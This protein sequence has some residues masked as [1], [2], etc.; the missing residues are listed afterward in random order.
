MRAVKAKINIDK[1]KVCFRAN[2]YLLN[3]LVDE[4][5]ND[6]T[7]DRVD[8]KL[9][10]IEQDE[11]AMTVALD[12]NIDEQIHRFGYFN[13]P[14]N[15]KYAKYVFFSFENR[16]LYTLF[17]NYEGRKSSI[18]MMIEDIAADMGLKF[19]NI[20]SVELAFDTNINVLAKVRKAI[21]NVEQ[22]DMVVNMKKVKTS[23]EKIDG[24]CEV[25]G[26]NRERIINPPMLYFRQKKDEGIRLKIYNKSREM[27]DASPAK[28]AYIPEWN[29]ITSTPIYRAEV[30]VRNEDI[31]DFCTRS[32]KD[33]GE[34]LF[35][36]FND[37]W[38]SALWLQCSKRVLHFYDR[39][40]GGIVGILDLCA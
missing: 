4:F 30:T 13:F 26:A 15:G 28:E 36:L 32:G 35:W 2:D 17:M 22:Y 29:D 10:L 18:A 19:N 11:D 21:K 14:L 27:Q 34:A 23:R 9:V 1:L 33:K 8:Y 37:E 6:T 7:I 38:R 25:Y 12:M 24:F 3:Y 31:A 39:A 20:T 5:K 40:T 16:A